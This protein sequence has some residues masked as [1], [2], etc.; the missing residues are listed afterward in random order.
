MSFVFQLKALVM[1]AAESIYAPLDEQFTN[2]QRL[3]NGVLHVT[4]SCANFRTT[5][6]RSSSCDPHCT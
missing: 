5:K 6:K 3:Q 4:A 1:E 2:V